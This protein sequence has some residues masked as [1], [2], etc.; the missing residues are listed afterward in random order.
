[1]AWRFGTDGSV[2]GNPTVAG[3]VAYAGSSDNHLYAVDVAT[4]TM[5]WNCQVPDIS[6]APTVAAGVVCAAGP[7]PG[8][9]VDTY[10]FFAIS[11]RTG[12]LL[13]QLAIQST[14]PAS[15]QSWAVSGGNVIVATQSGALQAYD[16]AT[17]AQGMTYTTAA[18]FSG[19]VAVDGS[20]IYALDNAGSVQAIS[21]STG[22]AQWHAQVLQ[23]GS[24]GGSLV[25]ADGTLYLGAGVGGTL[26]SMKADTGSVIWAHQ[27]GDDLQSALVIAHGAVYVTTTSELQAIAAAD[28]SKLWTGPAS[29]VSPEGGGPAVAYGQ[30]Y[31]CDGEKLQSLDAR[32]GKPEW[33]FTPS[34]PT[35]GTPAVAD[36][37]VFFGCGD[38]YLYAVRA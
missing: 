18:G 32:T 14:L 23:D 31:I 37:L 26:F 5:A 36:G 28:G 29:G 3:G 2:D 7:P 6:V 27:I 34:G 38:N 16:A 25:V 11:A 21:V 35:D 17:G 20:I 4:G 12:K 30:V 8:I 22:I 13:W 24:G 33:S 1:M 15:V 19:A 9:S 10:G